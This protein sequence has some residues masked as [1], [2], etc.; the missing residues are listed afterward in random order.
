MRKDIALHL[1]L[2]LE[3]EFADTINLSTPP[4]HLTIEDAFKNESDTSR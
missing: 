4:R 3:K 2:D 1:D